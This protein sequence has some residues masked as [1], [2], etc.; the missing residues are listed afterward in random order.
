[1]AEIQIDVLLVSA[2]QQ[3]AERIRKHAAGEVSFQCIPT[4]PAPGTCPQARQVWV[5]LDSVEAGEFPAAD[6]RVY[7]YSGRKPASKS[8]P[9]GLLIRKPCTGVVLHLLWAAAA[10]PSAPLAERPPET[11]T[12]CLLPA[13][14][15]DFQELQLNTLCRKL[16]AGLAPRLGYQHVSLYLHDFDAGRLTLMQT[17]HQRPLEQHLPMDAAQ[18]HLMVAVARSGR[19]FRT[20]HT[21][22]ELAARGIPTRDGREYDDDTCL[23]AP[24]ASDGRVCGVLNF[25]GRARTA[26]T[27]DN[28]PLDEIFAFLGRML[29]NAL[30]YDQA[31]TEAR[32][33][34][35][36]GLYNVRWLME[37]LE[38][39]I[40]R[41]DRFKTPLAV[42]MIDLDGLKAINDSNGHAAG[43]C[44]LQHTA[45][46]ITRVLRQFDS[47]A[48]IGGD[49]F[50]VMLPGTNRRGARHVAERLLDSIRADAASFR[51]SS[52]PI[53]VSV[54]AAEWRTGWTASQLIDAADHAMYGAKRNGRDGLVCHAPP[55]PDNPTPET[56]SPTAPRISSPH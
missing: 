28:L 18:Q 9:G 50:V 55:A 11:T 16:V 45:E 48:R 47:A 6:R 37:S 13:W 43:D 33:D 40:R 22:V 29:S 7:F 2:D 4:A 5:D 17:T 39:E 21:P 41:A 12:D 27:Q 54:G 14:L 8:L 3:F 25:S 51:G 20:E 42:L 49:E 10:Q 24:L 30:A 15:L 46:R 52:L 36:T 56:S 32:V 35:L 19:I 1:M 31:R 23:I 26:L 34:G 53:S 38:K 44:V